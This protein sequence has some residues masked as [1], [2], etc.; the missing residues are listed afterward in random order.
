MREIPEVIPLE[1][2]KKV[3]MSY[4]QI[5]SQQESKVKQEKDKITTEL[6]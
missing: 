2:M 4:K 1:H 5:Y 3:F 6:K